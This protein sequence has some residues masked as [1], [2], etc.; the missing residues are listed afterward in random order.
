MKKTIEV[1]LDAE[2][3]RQQLLCLNRY[4][5]TCKDKKDSELLEGALAVLEHVYDC[6]NPIPY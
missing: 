2:L 1:N 5:I 3:L 6:L 4:L